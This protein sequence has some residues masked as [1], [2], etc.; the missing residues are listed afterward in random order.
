MFSKEIVRS[1]AFLDMPTSSQLLYFQL[2][3]EAD[4]D[5]FVDNAKTISRMTSTSGDDLKILFTK[6]FLLSFE[7]GLLVIKHWKINNYINNRST[8]NSKIQR[9]T[10][11]QK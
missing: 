3:M 1:D 11:W 4:D 9:D 6:R 8:G 2:G 5:G 10:R 7:N